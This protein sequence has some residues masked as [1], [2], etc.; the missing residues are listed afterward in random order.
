MSLS[1]QLHNSDS[2]SQRVLSRTEATRI[3]PLLPHCVY[4]FNIAALIF[5][6]FCVQHHPP[7]T[8]IRDQQQKQERVITTTNAY[9][10]TQQ[11]ESSSK[12]AFTSASPVPAIAVQLSPT[13]TSSQH[14]SCPLSSLDR[15]IGIRSTLPNMVRSLFFPA[16]CSPASHRAT[17]ALNQ[18]A[19]STRTPLPPRWTSAQWFAVLVAESLIRKATAFGWRLGSAVVASSSPSLTRPNGLSSTAPRRTSAISTLI[20]RRPSLTL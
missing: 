13:T 1:R 12:C 8:L 6:V 9:P 15:I 4:I 19:P 20:M 2:C 16:R 7:R 10:K 14:V 3:I 5:R 18:P 11:T 17:C